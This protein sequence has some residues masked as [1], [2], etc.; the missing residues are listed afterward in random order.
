MQRFL[1]IAG[2]AFVFGLCLSAQN[3]RP[4]PAPAD[5]VLDFTVEGAQHQFHLGELIPARYSYTAA[6][7]GRYVW[8]SQ[9]QN[10]DGGHGLKISC[11]PSA[12]RVTLSPPPSPEWVKFQAML[13]G[14]CGGVGGGV[15][16][17]CGDCNWEQPLG[18]SLSFGPIPL[19]TFIRFRAPGPY[20]CTAS[21]ADVTMADAEGSIRPALLVKSG[22]VVLTIVSDPAWANSVI[23]AYA[24]VYDRVC[25]DDKAAK[26]HFLQCSDIAQRITYLDTRRSLAVEVQRFDGRSHGWQNGFWSAIQNS[27]Y[28]GDGVHMMT[29]R[30]QD[31]DVGVS[32]QVVQWLAIRD[33][34]LEDPGAF[35]SP[36][37]ALYHTAA[38]EKLRKYVRLLGSSLA[39]KDRAVRP[40]DIKT[41]RW[42]AEQPYCGESSLIPKEERDQV[43][44]AA[45]MR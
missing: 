30:I 26:E 17:G 15:G 21:A 41:Y 23:S 39:R 42:F 18:G 28:P 16:G 7:P 4:I 45:G 6:T 31:P 25:T 8:V 9:S 19:N 38:M 1:L 43:L 20:A 24:A 22:P 5:L 12:E 14:T 27:S 11:S 36:D 33:L 13:Q 2:A 37:A 3:D 29:Q 35:Q 34:G 44:A 10:L 40:D 32:P